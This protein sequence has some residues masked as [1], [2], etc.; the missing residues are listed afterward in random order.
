MCGV[1]CWGAELLHLRP[2]VQLFFKM[3]RKEQAVAAIGCGHLLWLKGRMRLLLWSWSAVCLQLV[4]APARALLRHSVQGVGGWVYVLYKTCLH[5]VGNTES[6]LHL[7]K[8]VSA[9][10]GGA[11]MYQSRL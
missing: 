5:V 9:C 8:H 11:W 4:R 7:Q 10:C 6:T 1:H 3:D 2:A